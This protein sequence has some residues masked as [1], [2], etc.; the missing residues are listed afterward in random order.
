MKFMKKI[1]CLALTLLCLGSLMVGC[2]DKEKEKEEELSRYNILVY[3]KYYDDI[4]HRYFRKDLLCEISKDDEEKTI[5]L[6]LLKGSHYTLITEEKYI[7][8]RRWNFDQLTQYDL[9]TYVANDGTVINH[10]DENEHP[11]LWHMMREGKYIWYL[12][13]NHPLIEHFGTMFTVIIT[14]EKGE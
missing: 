10:L 11:I 2:V 6:P 1:F 4:E 12:Q 8:G 13:A 14:E 9:L 3:L 5:E 7:S